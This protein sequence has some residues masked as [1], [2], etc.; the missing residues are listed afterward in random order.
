MEKSIYRNAYSYDELST[1][2]SP[3][4]YGLLS[5]FQESSLLLGSSSLSVSIPTSLI[6]ENLPQFTLPDDTTLCAGDTLFI[7]LT[8]LA[9]ISIK[10]EDNSNHL[11]RKI[12]APGI[13]FVQVTDNSGC[14]LTD[15][16]EVAYNENEIPVLD[17]V[18]C[19]GDFLILANESISLP[20]IYHDT[21]RLVR[22]M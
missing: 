17:T 14:D 1:I 20:G 7:D 15:T 12:N 9:P 21:L 22:F 3:D 2:D 11:V 6:K 8:D 5:S 4:Q 10:W 16:I 19:Q 18:L 13:Y